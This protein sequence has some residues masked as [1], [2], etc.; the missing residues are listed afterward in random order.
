[1]TS[2][3]SPSNA[4]ITSHLWALAVSSFEDHCSVLGRHL[5]LRQWH[6]RRLLLR[7]VA[8]RDGRPGCVIDGCEAAGHSKGLCLGQTSCLDADL[9]IW[10]FVPDD[11]DGLQ[12]VGDRRNVSSDPDG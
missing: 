4:P 2:K 3:L 5:L 11:G 12:R 6:Q 1:M 8:T 7:A 10:C 9:D